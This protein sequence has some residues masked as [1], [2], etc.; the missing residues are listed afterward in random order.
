MKQYWSAAAALLALSTTTGVFAQDTTVTPTVF[1][2]SLGTE[3]CDLLTRNF[4]ATA[5]LGSQ[6]FVLS[7][8]VNIVDSINAEDV[9]LGFDGAG[10]YSVDPAVLAGLNVFGT[11][12]TMTPEQS[13]DATLALLE[14]FDANLN[15]TIT[16]PEGQGLP[17]D[18]PLTLQLAL[19]DGFGYIDFDTLQMLLGANGGLTGWG[20]VDLVGVFNALALNAP[21]LFDQM[22]NTQAV[23]IDPDLLARFSD[24]NFAQGFSTITRTD[25]GDSGQATFV[26]TIDFAAFSQTPE[27]QTL[28]DQSMA[29]T[30][31][32]DDAA[33][34]Q[35]RELTSAVL[36]ALN[37]TLTQTIDETTGFTTTQT[38]DVSVDGA[39]IQSEL[40]QD[41]GLGAL[42]LVLTIDYADHNAVSS[43]AA[44]ENAAIL[45]TEQV[46]A[47]FGI[48]G[49]FE[50]DMLGGTPE[51]MPG[52]E[53]TPE[54]TPG[55]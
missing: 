38:I 10:A 19:V 7:G 26:T 39:D 2:G 27:F 16:L 32:M 52:M 30:P 22:L 35:Q 45:P 50:S 47:Q 54:A 17:G 49:S 21:G 3:D 13:F 51:A 11:D 5:T 29:T 36:S 42:S 43:I 1:C 34:A 46:L 55:M 18:A 25:A 20:G 37:L 8:D 12:L 4:E 6:S 24:P 14:G 53:M 9:A 15:L 40:V 44:P 41:A 28:L 31:G 23:G 48:S 33:T